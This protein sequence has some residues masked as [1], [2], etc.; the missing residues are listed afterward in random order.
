[1]GAFLIPLLLLLWA[2]HTASVAKRPQA[3]RLCVGSLTT[4]LVGLA[5]GLGGSGVAVV[6]QENATGL[7]IRR[8]GL[9]V[10]LLALIASLTMAVAGLATRKPE[11]TRGKG[12]AITT[13]VLG[14]LLLFAFLSMMAVGVLQSI[15]GNTTSNASDN[16]RESLG[17]TAISSQV[18]RTPSFPELGFEVRNVPAFW[19]SLNPEIIM[20][21]AAIV[22]RRAKPE[23]YWAVIAEEMS[24]ELQLDNDTLVEIVKSNLLGAS[25]SAR[26]GEAQ[27]ATL[28]GLPATRIT[29]DA[30]VEGFDAHYVFGVMVTDQRAYQLISWSHQKDCESM[31]PQSQAMAERFATLAVPVPADMPEGQEQEAEST[32][33]QEIQQSR[34]PR[35]PY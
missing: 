7:V 2:A 10:I 18:S 34:P 1:V 16:A 25:P 31:E 13:L 24:S 30:T 8:I 21:D 20:P 3:S 12:S 9:I 29:A 19:V 32:D 14:G 27:Q 11:M 35:A 5:L 33:A 17:K 4:L 23:I 26:F 15:R 22:L 6:M 28:A